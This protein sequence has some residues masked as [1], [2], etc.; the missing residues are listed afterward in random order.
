M[1]PCSAGDEGGEGGLVV[2]GGRGRLEG[3]GVGKVVGEE[4]VCKEIVA[5]LAKH[6]R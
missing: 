6:R 4:G 5:G 1:G 3:P 2:E